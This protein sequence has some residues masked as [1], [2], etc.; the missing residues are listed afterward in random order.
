MNSKFIKAVTSSIL[1]A[2]ILTACA[3][4]N[5]SDPYEKNMEDYGTENFIQWDEKEGKAYILHEDGTKEYVED[6]TKDEDEEE[7]NFFKGEYFSKG[8]SLSI[9]GDWHAIDNGT[10]LKILSA[11]NADS[12]DFISIATFDDTG[13]DFTKSWTAE[14]LTSDYNKAVE[15]GTYK[16]VEFIESNN[17]K[18]KGYDAF[19]YKCKITSTSDTS[20]I[21]SVYMIYDDFGGHVIMTNDEEDDVN[22]QEEL[23]YVIK[24][25]EFVNTESGNEMADD[26]LVV[27][28]EETSSEASEITDSSKI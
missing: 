17:D 8:F 21:F 20:S 14:T 4:N 3:N 15:E 23:D 5:S 19:Y 13:M 2:T 18:I 27:S 9:N 25:I 28:D 6:T 16:S 12:K 10:D 1:I 22:I 24:N 11:N 26:E 7:L